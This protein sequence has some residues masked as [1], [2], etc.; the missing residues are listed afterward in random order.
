[1][2]HTLLRASMSV[3]AW[4]HGLKLR[5]SCAGRYGADGPPG[6]TDL[7]FSSGGVM[8]VRSAGCVFGSVCGTGG[9]QEEKA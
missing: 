9:D 7:T 6:W 1:M 8:C 2:L 3:C 5:V 4:V